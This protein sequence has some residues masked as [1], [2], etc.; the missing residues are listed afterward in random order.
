[1]SE[2]ILVAVTGVGVALINMI[3]SVLLLWI[4][5]HYKWRNGHLDGGDPTAQ[6]PK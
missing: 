6:P 4:R 5:A 2:A 1:M 3:G